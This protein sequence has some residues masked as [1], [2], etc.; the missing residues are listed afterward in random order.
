MTV[1]WHKKENNTKL[2]LLF[3]G[4][5]FD[6]R[7]FSDIDLPGYDCVS[8][9]DY[10]QID[11]LQFVFTQDYPEVKV[12]AWSYGVFI[13]NMYA[14]YLQPVQKAVAVNGTTT[15]INDEKGIPENIFKATIHSFSEKSKNKFYL[16]IAGGATN[17]QEIKEKLPMR[18]IES[19]LSELK[20]LQLLSTREQGKGL[21]WDAAIVSSNDKIFPADNML[22]AWGEKAIRKEGEHYTDFSAIIKEY[23]L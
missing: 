9:C 20:A 11:P 13:A 18:D 22:H 7:I 3:N 15:P 6:S 14:Q 12:L 17:F 23:I 19:Q 10:S 4:W 1:Y 2:L 16:R 5:G 8:V 21:L